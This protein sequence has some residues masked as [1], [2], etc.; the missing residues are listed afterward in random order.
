MFLIM[1]SKFSWMFEIEYDPSG[2]SN[3]SF[4]VG[5]EIL[6]VLFLYADLMFFPCIINTQISQCNI[7]IHVFKIKLV[8]K[9]IKKFAR[10]IFF[11]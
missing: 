11:Y 10:L 1:Y 2:K 9:F 4:Q 8:S 3:S 7:F 6:I 5:A